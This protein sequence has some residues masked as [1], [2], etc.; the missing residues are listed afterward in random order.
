MNSENGCFQNATHVE[1]KIACRWVN[2]FATDAVK[3][4]DLKMIKLK[5]TSDLFSIVYIATEMKLD[6][7]K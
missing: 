4:K 5:G 6:V 7:Q 2:N 1:K 3:M